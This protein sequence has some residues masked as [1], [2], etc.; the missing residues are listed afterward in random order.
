MPVRLPVWMVTCRCCCSHCRANSTQPT[1]VGKQRGSRLVELHGIVVHGQN[2]T[3]YDLSSAFK[4]EVDEYGTSVPPAFANGSLCILP[5][6]GGPQTHRSRRKLSHRRV[7]AKTSAAAVLQHASAA[8]PE[9][10][11]LPSLGTMT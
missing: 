10:M 2:G 8:S 3:V 7:L 5:G 9:E 11:L 1:G 6:D 4:P